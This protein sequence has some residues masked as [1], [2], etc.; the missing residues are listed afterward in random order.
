MTREQLINNIL[1]FAVD[2]K[3]GRISET[4]FRNYLFSDLNHYEE[5]QAER[6]IKIMRGVEK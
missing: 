6:L 3:E 5:A 2:L 1:L 4:G